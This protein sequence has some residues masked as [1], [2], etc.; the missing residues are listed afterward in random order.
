[1]NLLYVCTN[2]YF[3]TH[4][5]LCPNITMKCLKAPFHR[6]SQNPFLSW[7]LTS[8]LFPILKIYHYFLLIHSSS[9][10][11]SPVSSAQNVHSIFFLLSKYGIL[12]RTVVSPAAF[13]RGGTFSSYSPVTLGP[14]VGVG[15]P[16][17]PL[18]C[19]QT[20]VPSTHP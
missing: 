18:C 16:F 3:Y 4:H 20:I 10:E 8:H 12:S 1:M 15:I 17:V 19:F 9:P 6:I 2:M 14:E 13:S 5:C 7:L 11:K